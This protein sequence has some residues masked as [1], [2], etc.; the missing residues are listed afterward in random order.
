MR[1]TK[2]I[3]TLGVLVAITASAHAAHV[4]KSGDITASETWTADNVYELE[5]TVAVRE[6]ATL[7][8]EAGTIIKSDFDPDNGEVDSVLLINR[9]AQIFV[10]GTPD[11]P[12]VFTST[13]DGTPTGSDLGGL[14]LENNE[15]GS[16]AV[17]GRARIGGLS[18]AKGTSN[19][20]QFQDGPGTPILTNTGMPDHAN[21]NEMEGVE[22]SDTDTNGID[23]DPRALYGGLDD[24]DDSGSIK[25]ISVRYA[26][27]FG[28]VNNS[29]LNGMS[30]GGVGRGTDIEGVDI[31][32]NIDDGIEIFGGTVNFKKVSIWNI[33][34]D[35]FDVDEGWR[36]KAQFGL[37]VQGA[38]G[39]GDQGSGVG[40]NCF[41][42]DGG[43]PSW[44]QPLTTA[45]IYNFTAIGNPIGGDHATAWRDGARVQY[46]NCLFMDIGDQLIKEEDSEKS[47]ATGTWRYGD[48]PTF[49]G[50]GGFGS[51]PTF[52][53]LFEYAYTE[54]HNTGNSDT[55]G[56]PFAAGFSQAQLED[57][58]DA[59]TPGNA[60]YQGFMAEMS[61]SVF[62]NIASA[63]KADEVGPTG[64][65]TIVG[66]DAVTTGNATL[67][68]VVVT[69][70]P[71]SEIIRQ[72]DVDSPTGDPI[73]VQGGKN[74]P[75]V[76][77]LDP[78]PVGAAAG[79]V[80]VAAPGDADCVPAPY[81]GGFSPTTNWAV[82]WTAADQYGIFTGP[83][84]PADPDTEIELATT[85][86]SFDTVN[87][88]HYLI[89][90]STDG[91]NWTPEAVIEGDGG[92]A[93]IAGELGGSFDAAKL[94][95]V[96]PL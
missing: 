54:V 65:G 56:H 93:S 96:T 23:D 6:G 29:E 89:E 92:T 80:D 53:E 95:R 51:V 62:Y 21:I 25:Y 59:Q 67:H 20:L 32:C 76:E 19:P 38:G 64:L 3:A 86:V 42:H 35:S 94:Y 18:N 43:Q 33:G 16:I 90:S 36:G 63:G 46:R 75:I 88:V 74:I 28:G 31:W 77:R 55:G 84:N 37:I 61:N 1:I 68:N 22:N 24:D 4:I 15:W 66:D 73:R 5:G 47:T 12:V 39:T 49:A 83:A 45:A 60:G 8:I 81:V 71:I 9:G 78:R 44:V 14:R 41:E 69:T 52:A 13:S 10:Q 40:D 85:V 87:G 30:F 48:N 34:D 82:G 17:E 7:T 26:G 70:E 2:A 72:G 11:N 57:L 27:R 58:Y 50:P 79:P 91:T